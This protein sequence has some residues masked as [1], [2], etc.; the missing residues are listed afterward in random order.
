MK[1]MESYEDELYQEA[2]RENRKLRNQLKKDKKL[3]IKKKRELK[4][5][6]YAY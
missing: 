3:N 6:K 4:Y 1:Q 5:L 2:Y